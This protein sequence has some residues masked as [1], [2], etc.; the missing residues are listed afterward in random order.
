[1]C[2]TICTPHLVTNT[3]SQ[4]SKVEAVTKQA[5]QNMGKRDSF[6]T[7]TKFSLEFAIG[8]IKKINLSNRI[9]KDRFLTGA[10]IDHDCHQSHCH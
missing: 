7:C 5:C 3:K 4:Y 2:S 10:L 8:N 9:L 6:L 1:M